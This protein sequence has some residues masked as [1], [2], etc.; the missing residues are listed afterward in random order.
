MADFSTPTGRGPLPPMAPNT[1]SGR[2]G[3]QGVAGW[4]LLLCLMLTVV[5]PLITAG[6]LVQHH[7][8]WPPS[9][10]GLR[11]QP[12]PALLLAL[13]SVLVEAGSIVYGLYAGLRLWLL[14]PAAVNTAKAALLW[15][16]VASVAT[17][18]LQ[19]LA[20][21]TVGAAGGLLHTINLG[22]LPDLVFFTASF[23]YLNKSAR[24][25]ATYLV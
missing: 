7:L 14:R 5:G 4:L 2:P 8:G 19:W 21:P 15:G 18:T 1:A 11:S 17:L 9:L 22:L 20:G 13:A 25:Q 6:L 24:V 16:L 12:L 3:P 23:A 10:A